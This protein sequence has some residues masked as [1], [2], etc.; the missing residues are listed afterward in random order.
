MLMRGG[1]SIC[2]ICCFYV[3]YAR[4]LYQHLMLRTRKLESDGESQICMNINKEK[5]GDHFYVNKL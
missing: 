2:F 1:C 3:I 5:W 4:A